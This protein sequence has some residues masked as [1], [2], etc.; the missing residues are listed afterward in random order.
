MTGQACAFTAR[1]ATFRLSLTG[2]STPFLSKLGFAPQLWQK[3]LFDRRIHVSSLALIT[4]RIAH[5]ALTN[6]TEP[7][8][9]S[10]NDSLSLLCRQHC[11]VPKSLDWEALLQKWHVELSA[12]LTVA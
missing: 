10:A 7:L 2:A 11:T 6:D 5:R 1:L 8:K 9:E 3:E 4:P 12:R